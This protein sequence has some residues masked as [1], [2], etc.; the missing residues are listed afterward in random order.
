VWRGYISKYLQVL[1]LTARKP[2][3]ENA[4]VLEENKSNLNKSDPKP[5]LNTSAYV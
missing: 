3:A 4:A 1:T 2:T 5:I